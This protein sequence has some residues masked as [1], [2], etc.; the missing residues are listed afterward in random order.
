MNLIFGGYMFKRWL[1]VIALLALNI[2]CSDNST[3]PNNQSLREK[4]EAIPGATVV[5]D[6]APYG[7]QAVHI[8]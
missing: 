5:V 7:F 4:L 1:A 3:S 8:K 6:G 2:S